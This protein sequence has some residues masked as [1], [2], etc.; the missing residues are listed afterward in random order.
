MSAT[1][2]GKP[3]NAKAT[4]KYITGLERYRLTLIKEKVID[5]KGRLCTPSKAN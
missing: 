1:Y 3:L 2:K 5:E 4:P